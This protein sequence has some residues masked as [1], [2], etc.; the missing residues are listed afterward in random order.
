MTG[1]RGNNS[2]TAAR[3]TKYDPT[4][5]VDPT[6]NRLGQALIED[7]SLDPWLL[8]LGLFLVDTI[9]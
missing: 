1:H 7:W 4:R 9:R 3:R 6:N 2:P 5:V 8:P